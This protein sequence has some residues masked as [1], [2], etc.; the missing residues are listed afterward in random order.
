MSGKAR[1]EIAAYPL[2]TGDPGVSREVSRIF[3]ALDRRGLDYQITV[4]G[5]VV[6]GAVDELFLLARDLHETVFSDTV[7][8]VVTVMRIDDKRYD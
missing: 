4:M 7:R 8:R 1:M 2:E 3:E 6:E 5:T